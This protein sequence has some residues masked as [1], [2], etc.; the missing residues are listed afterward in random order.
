MIV[1]VLRRAVSKYLILE[2]TG[3]IVVLLQ[4]ATSPLWFCFNKNFSR[5]FELTCWFFSLSNLHSSPWSG[6][7]YKPGS[8]VLDVEV[9]ETA[10]IA[11][12]TWLGSRIEYPPTHKSHFCSQRTKQN[13][14]ESKCLQD[15]PKCRRAFK[16][17]RNGCRTW[18]GDADKHGGVRVDVGDRAEVH[19]SFV[20]VVHHPAHYTVVQHLFTLY[21]T[22]YISLS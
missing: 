22:R 11:K 2:I 6:L 9:H 13:K 19:R 10:E 12:S 14:K 21:T 16:T 3:L 1:S 8:H 15:S 17:H 20:A 7:G 18:C 4:N 5:Y